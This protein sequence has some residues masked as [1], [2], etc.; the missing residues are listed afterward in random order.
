MEV[1]RAVQDHDVQIDVVPRLFDVIS[2]KIAY[3]GR[4]LPDGRPPASEC[5]PS[6]QLV[7]RLIDVVGIDRCSSSTLPLF[8][9]AAFAIPDLFAGTRFLSTAPYSPGDAQSPFC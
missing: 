5:S 9:G 3:C 1:I 8:V 6:S 4:G 7:K 2:Q